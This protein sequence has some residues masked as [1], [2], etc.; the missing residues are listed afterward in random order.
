MI[1]SLAAVSSSSTMPRAPTRRMSVVRQDRNPLLAAVPDHDPA[2][3]SFVHAVALL[4]RSGVVVPYV[5]V[6]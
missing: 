5:E 6:S 2:L 3:T 4:A 1:S